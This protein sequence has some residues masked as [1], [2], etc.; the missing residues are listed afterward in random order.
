MSERL[1]EEGD[2]SVEEELR[3]EHGSLERGAVG[4]SDRRPAARLSTLRPGESGL[5]R[6]VGGRG[7]L[8]QRLLDMGLVPDVVI[9]VERWAPTGDPIWVSVEGSH[10]ALRK[11]EAASVLVARP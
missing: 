10:L 11:S 7:V 1:R 6:E 4:P 8:R 3:S 2:R 9:R 5:V